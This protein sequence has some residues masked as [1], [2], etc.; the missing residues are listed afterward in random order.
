MGSNSIEN[1]IIQ[2]RKLRNFSHSKE[3]ITDED[4]TEELRTESIVENS[5]SFLQ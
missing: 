4:L 5:E 2:K 3:E 1:S